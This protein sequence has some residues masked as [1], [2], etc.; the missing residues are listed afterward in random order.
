MYI[1][2]RDPFQIWEA[3]LPLRT[4]TERVTREKPMFENVD[5]IQGRCQEPKT[6][7][8]KATKFSDNQ[9]ENDPMT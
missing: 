3:P 9:R 6:L 2:L 8:L 5:Q 1:R 4:D 7:K